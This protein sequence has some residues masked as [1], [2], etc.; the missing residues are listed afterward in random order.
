MTGTL[1]ILSDTRPDTNLDKM[2][3]AVKLA[4]NNP[5]FSKPKKVL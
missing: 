4:R 5:L 1:P 3:N 2:E